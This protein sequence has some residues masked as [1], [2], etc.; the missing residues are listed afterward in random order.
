[1]LTIDQAAKDVPHGPATYLLG[2]RHG[3]P[4]RPFNWTEATPLP[5]LEKLKGKDCGSYGGYLHT[6]HA[7]RAEFF[8]PYDA[9]PLREAPYLMDFAYIFDPASPDYPPFMVGQ[10]VTEEAVQAELGLPRDMRII[11]AD[12]AASETLQPT[13]PR[14]FTKR[15]ADALERTRAWKLTDDEES[16]LR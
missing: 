13:R 4:L 7:V 5:A 16:G 6:D 3:K 11:A 2:Q 9:P 10:P 8:Q 14:Q 15:V 12:E 1:M